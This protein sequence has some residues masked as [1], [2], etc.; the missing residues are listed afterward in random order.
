MTMKGPFALLRESVRFYVTHFMLLSGIFLI[1]TAV[2]ISSSLL[3]LGFA[4]E[5]ISIVVG[6]F[7]YIALIL[8]IDNP[9]NIG[10]VQRAFQA[11]APLFFRYLFVSVIVGFLLMLGIFALLLPG[12]LFMV[13]FMPSSFVVVLENRGVE[14]TLK[15]S[16]EYTRGKW[17]PIFLRLVVL[18]LIL[19]TI[20][21]PFAFLF[22][23]TGAGE[24]GIYIVA[25]LLTPF[26][27][28]YLYLLYQ[29]VKNA[30]GAA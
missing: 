15:Q 5:I 24:I 28:V 11:S 27:Y 10:T 3:S 7:S 12:L 2:D 4:G 8:A 13:W 29:E 22:G 17:S 9:K 1:P 19:F 25:W 23:V 20:I 21:S 30:Q 26:S 16:R 14:D 18:G 6:T